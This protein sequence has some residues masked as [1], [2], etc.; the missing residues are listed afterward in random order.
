M[1]NNTDNPDPY[2]EECLLGDL[3]N[4]YMVAC[5]R[6]RYDRL[7]DLDGLPEDHTEVDEQLDITMWINDH[8]F[9]ADEKKSVLDMLTM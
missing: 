5:V 7:H 6:Y 2:H 3:G 1:D 9:N 4:K 8:R